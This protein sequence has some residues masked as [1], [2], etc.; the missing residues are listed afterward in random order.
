MD[1]DQFIRDIKNTGRIT[2]TEKESK[3]V[4]QQYGVPV[5]EEW[6]VRTA[7]DAV[8][9]A[10]ELDYPVVL[11][12]MGA[13]LT[14]KTERGLVKLNLPHAEALRTAAR[15]IVASAGE[16]LEGFL[17]QPQVRGRREFAAGLFR[18]AQFGPVIM[19]GLGG[20]FT[21]ALDDVIF[22]LAPLDETDVRH[23]IG[24]LR[25]R[26]LLA[27]FRGDEPAHME[28]LI[29]T[30]LGLS[31]LAC[32]CPEIKEVDI[33]P[34]I[35]TADGRARAVDALIVLTERDE[36]AK[37]PLLPAPPNKVFQMFA[38]RSVALIGAS[39]DI[40][41]WGFRVYSSIVS[42]KYEGRLYLVNSKGGKI[43]GR[44]A[45][46]S[47]EE[48][49]EPVD[50]AI[51]TVP[52]EGVIDLLPAL[53]VKGIKA[54]LLI[55]SG[56]GETGPEGRLLEHKLIASAR[57]A[58]VLILGPNTMGL[59]DP[60]AR[61]YSTGS[62]SHPLP[63][64]I[65]FISQSGNLGWQAF[66]GAEREGIGVRCFVGSGN[67]SMVTIEDY[68]DGC[69]NDELTKTIVLYIE[70]VKNGR[71]FFESAR[72]IGRRKPVIV[73]KGGRTAEGNKAAA[74]H[75]GAMA[76]N[77]RVFDAACEQAGVVVVEQPSELFNV[78]AAISSL[79]LPSGKR[80]GIMSMGGGWAVA[81]TDLC[82]EQGLQ[83]PS[84][85]PEV[86]ARID[87]LLPPYWSRSNPLD[88]VGHLDPTV[89]FKVMEILMQWDG[90][91]AC[92]HFGVIG[93]SLLLKQL[94]ESALLTDPSADWSI[95]ESS[96]QTGKHL[97]TDYLE[98]L[99]RLMEKYGKPILGACV[100]HDDVDKTILDLV[101]ESPFK[102][103][104]FRTA[105]QVIHAMSKLC[106]YGQWVARVGGGG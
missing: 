12:G 101:R 43:A 90:C 56:F 40:R 19:F 48:I 46:R 41:K 69:E 91:D 45:Y 1:I 55:S 59:L 42:G 105:E 16:E 2:L 36:E 72:R 3:R 25:S 38:P 85:S 83:V 20:I 86:I 67:E 24:S 17:L 53:Q 37:T 87:R 66:S 70:S 21:E 8:A 92:I 60:H 9:K 64:S 77:K 81:A 74:S 97:E 7:D 65:A 6:A 10:E 84:L 63:G 32:A 82:V 26:K 95:F 88:L 106:A 75:T 39:A 34:L 57:Q 51:V 14:H 11:K 50:L 71:R 68:L 29:Q 30:L 33:N 61:F 99:V 94:H 89:P 13:R 49:T 96:I 79:P 76:S 27:A 98:G 44:T 100:W 62:P 103:I 80:V 4:L 102:A 22:R 31:R 5:V 18:D 93:Q 73:L 15:E 58:G 54:M 78:A 52:A 35:L 104:V 23:M 28:D 47:I